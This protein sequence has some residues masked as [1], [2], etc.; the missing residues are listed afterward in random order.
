MS[1]LI[2]FTDKGF[3]CP[4]ADVY[5]DPWKSVNKALITHGHSDH[6]RRGH[7][8]YLCHH[9]SVD[10]LKYRLGKIKVQGIAYDKPIVMNGVRISYHP[11]GHVL[12]SAQIKLDNGKQSWVISG[13]Y[14]LDDDGVAQ[15]FEPVECTHFV[16]E[17]TFGLPVFNWEKQEDI[18]SQINNWWASNVKNNRPSII[19]AYSLGKAQRVLANIDAEIGPIVV[20]PSIDAINKITVQT[21]IAMPVTMLKEEIATEDRQKALYICPQMAADSKWTSGLKSSS[22]AVVSGWM[23]LRGAKRRRNID[24][25]FV[26]SD[27]A[28]WGGLNQA[29]K[30]TG[31]QNIYV[32]HGYT[33]TYRKWLEHE[34]YMAKVVATEYEGES[35]EKIDNQRATE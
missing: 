1:D 4:Q 6:A 23:G 17:C 20:H 35:M 26:L 7:K 9:H 31:A 22:S 5:I 32:T 3:Y 33:D 15:A 11:A 21:G 29:V 19:S 13:D 18:F 25:G 8:S 2:I 24:R 30:D 28:D 12:G 16:T 10:I 14:K 27:H 34:G